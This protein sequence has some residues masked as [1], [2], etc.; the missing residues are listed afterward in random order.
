MPKLRP[1]PRSAGTTPSAALSRTP[2]PQD[3]LT[4]PSRRKQSGAR[5]IRVRHGIVGST[6]HEAT[7][8][9]W[10]ACQR[11][12][13]AGMTPHNARPGAS[14]RHG[15]R[16][17]GVRRGIARHRAEKAPPLELRDAQVILARS[18][19]RQHDNNSV[20]GRPP[21]G[22]PHPRAQDRAKSPNRYKMAGTSPEAPR[23]RNPHGRGAPSAGPQRLNIAMRMPLSPWASWQTADSGA[24][25]TRTLADMALHLATACPPL[26]ADHAATVVRSLS[27]DPNE[28]KLER[29]SPRRSND[30]QYIEGP[31]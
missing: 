1:R 21:R 24:I 9:Q 28:P 4:A 8:L 11:T 14:A 27:P 5:L 25:E 22:A 16:N 15:D 17:P 3:P 31:G 18:L 20:A 12:N 30:A 29:S 13:L 2:V 6:S 23:D 26:H 19:W 10:T 7:A